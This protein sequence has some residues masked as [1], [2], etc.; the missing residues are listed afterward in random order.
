MKKNPQGL[1]KPN[2]LIVDDDDRYVV[3]LRRMLQDDAHTID[4][5][6]SCDAAL[7]RITGGRESYYDV[8]ILDYSL[9][10]GKSGLE[11]L[12]CLK[13][14][15][16]FVG[17][18]I[19]LTGRGSREIGV[20]AMREGAFRYFTKQSENDDELLCAIEVA[21]D[22]ARARRANRDLVSA[23][24]RTYAELI[25]ICVIAGLAIGGV[26]LLKHFADLNLTTVVA[27]AGFALVLFLGVSGVG[28]I[29][30]GWTQGGKAGHITAESNAKKNR[31]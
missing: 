30:F 16:G 8:V 31:E 26:I 19:V 15:V 4:V 24:K 9:G 12:R 18:V 17:D 1:V 13:R 11:C 6:I 10:Q 27:V 22:M 20:A 25:L 5:A 21:H 7:E 28:R 29:R 23:G 14:I 3:A 2:L